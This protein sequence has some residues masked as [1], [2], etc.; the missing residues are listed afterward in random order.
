MTSEEAKTFLKDSKEQWAE[1][2]KLIQV[3][4]NDALLKYF[5]N[6]DKLFRAASL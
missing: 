5:Q 4:K 1:V 3:C 6:A 2:M